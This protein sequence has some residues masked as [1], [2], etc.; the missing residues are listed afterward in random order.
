MAWCA[1]SWCHCRHA[2]N[3]RIDYFMVNI[4][5]MNIMV[6]SERHSE[7]TETACLSCQWKSLMP[8]IMFMH[9]LNMMESMMAN[10][11]T[12]FLPVIPINRISNYW[13][14]SESWTW[15]HDS[16][17]TGYKTDAKMIPFSASWRW[18]QLMIPWMNS[19][20][21]MLAGTDLIHMKIWYTGQII[22]WH[23]IIS[24]YCDFHE[25]HHAIWNDA[26]ILF[27]I[28]NHKY[29]SVNYDSRFQSFDSLRRIQYSCLTWC[30]HCEQGTDDYGWMLDNMNKNLSCWSHLR[31][32]VWFGTWITMQAL[33]T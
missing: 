10:H 33:N 29:D 4:F 17:I 6:T 24:S 1:G 27:S 15:M 2:D 5:G 25:S 18:H 26:S 8:W 7:W 13:N 14:H 22:W 32:M 20:N 19:M 9:S 30:V 31:R 28:P 3:K 21:I 12:W 11:W 16:S 23:P